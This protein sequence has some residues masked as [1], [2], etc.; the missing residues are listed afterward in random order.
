MVSQSYGPNVEALTVCAAA[1]MWTVYPGYSPDR[2][3]KSELIPSVRHNIELAIEV[4]RRDHAPNYRELANARS[5]GVR[6]ASQ[7]VPLESVIQAYRSTER[8]ILLDLL[9]DSRS[10][11]AE[12][13]SRSADL[14]ITT[15][16]LLTEEM[17]NSY[18]ETSSDIDAA[19]RRMENELVMSV[20][21]GLPVTH[22]QIAGSIRILNIDVSAP[23]FAIALLSEAA[24]DGAQLDLQ[25][26]R[27]R[28]AAKLQPVASAVLFGDVGKMTV[29]LISPRGDA[30]NTIKALSSSLDSFAGDARIVC[31]V[32]ETT[33]ELGR[34]QESCS[35][36]GDSARAALIRRDGTSIVSYREA[37]LEVILSGRPAAAEA[38]VQSR[39]APLFAHPHLL[40]TLGTLFDEDLSQS[41]AARRMFVHVNTMGHRVKRITE[42]TGYDPTRT[43]DVVEMALALRWAHMTGVPAARG[44][45]DPVKQHQRS[46]KAGTGE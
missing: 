28:L 38:L 27:R 36:A 3:E 33:G 34:A 29:G 24:D 13:A 35:Q 16:D 15:F 39:L 6:R 18:R 23:W 5:L 25:R 17:I 44:G 41:R 30:E 32:G 46:T 45:A 21:S 43:A 10:W 12:Q 4:V 40:E 1:L 37:L 19:R 8:V 2:L 42:I 11:P 9:S 14:V 31:G 20:V 7:S 26:L 22:D